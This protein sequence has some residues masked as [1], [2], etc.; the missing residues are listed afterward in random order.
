MT[1]NKLLTLFLA[2][3]M[4][5]VSGCGPDTD[6]ETRTTSADTHGLQPHETVEQS[7]RA[8]KNNDIRDLLQ[9]SL[10]EAKYAEINA[11]WEARKQE[12]ITDE[13]REE[14]NQMMEMLTQDDAVDTIMTQVE[15]QLDQM[16]EQMPM[17]IGMFQGIAQ[18]AIT[19]NED[20]TVE[21]REQAQ[22]AVTAVA[23][24]AQR[25]DLASKE[26]AREA[27]SVAVDTAH[28]IDLPTLDDVRGLSFNGML[29]KAGVM[30]AG[31]KN[32]LAV[33]DLHV[34]DSLDSV[35]AET[36]EQD[37]ESATVRTRF[38]FLDTELEHEGA[39][40]KVGERWFAREAAEAN[41]EQVAEGD[42][43]V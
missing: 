20:M 34:D 42:E 1:I 30:V 14:Y 31:I 16:R 8:L 43:G 17:F 28:E 5:A 19:Q 2:G 24:W 18:S 37:G 21:Q 7:A 26:K 13:E 12:P 39:Y 40:V 11:Q 4:L 10:P 23:A 32:I 38:D 35:R 29:D 36:V 25:T 33:Y 15:P 22:R 9:I 27:V 41:I 3:T 6:T